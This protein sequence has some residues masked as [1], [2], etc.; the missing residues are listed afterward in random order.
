MKSKSF[1]A[2]PVQ[3]APGMAPPEIGTRRVV[4][5]TAE[6]A[7]LTTVEVRFELS[8]ASKLP[9]TRVDEASAFG[10]ACSQT[11]RTAKPISFPAAG[12]QARED[13]AEAAQA[14]VIEPILQPNS[15][16]QACAAKGTIADGNPA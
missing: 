10:P 11:V 1:F 8:R 2:G 6:S 9:F 14:R 13:S 3:A 15:G 16:Y 4:Q 5:A 12:Q 7:D